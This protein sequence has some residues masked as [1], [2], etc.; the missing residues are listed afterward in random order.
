METSLAP[1]LSFP[2]IVERCREGERRGGG[3]SAET[4]VAVGDIGLVRWQISGRWGGLAEDEALQARRAAVET[5]VNFLDT[6]DVRRRPQRA[7]DGALPAKG[8]LAS[9]RSSVVGAWFETGDCSALSNKHSPAI[10]P[11]VGIRAGNRERLSE[12]L[13]CTESAVENWEAQ[14]IAPVLRVS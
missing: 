4:G 9:G 2:R 5:G 12:G 7:P 3:N 13:G 1:L 8:G 6:P 14:H 11:G 10:L